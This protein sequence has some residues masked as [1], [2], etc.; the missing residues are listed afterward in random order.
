LAL[1]IVQIVPLALLVGTQALPVQPRSLQ[2]PGSAQSDAWLQATHTVPPVL[3]TCGAVQLAVVTHWTQLFCVA[4]PFRVSQTLPAGQSWFAT[5]SRQVPE[6]QCPLAQVSS[7]VMEPLPAAQA[8]SSGL[9]QKV[10]PPLRA[11]QLAPSR[12]GRLPAPVVQASPGGTPS[13]QT[14]L[15]QV[16]V[17]LQQRV[18]VQPVASSGTQTVPLPPSLDAPQT[19]PLQLRPRQQSSSLAHSTP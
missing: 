18:E 19:P 16:A 11:R 5:H 8:A 7:A 13:L 1:V 15:L 9:R 17:A 2:A 6:T 14:L 3:Q 4:S 12:Q 10:P